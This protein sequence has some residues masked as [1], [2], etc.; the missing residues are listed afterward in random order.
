MRARLVARA[1][2]QEMIQKDRKAAR[3]EKRKE[4][5]AGSREYS[6]SESEPTEKRKR[7]HS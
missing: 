4:Q 5:R 3:Q 7:T 2:F 1:T 6:A